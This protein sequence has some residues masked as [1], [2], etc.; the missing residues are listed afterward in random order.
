[1][2]YIHA[3]KTYALIFALLFVHYLHDVYKIDALVQVILLSGMIFMS[4]WFGFF[5]DRI[6]SI[7]LVNNGL[8]Q[9][10][11]AL[12]ALFTFGFFSFFAGAGLAIAYK[13]YVTQG[14]IMAILI[15]LVPM[16]P[17]TFLHMMALLPVWWKDDRDDIITFFERIGLK[18]KLKSEL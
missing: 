6:D 9:W 3:I 12:T 13:F 1:M 11:Y 15:S 2:T 17:A 14:F 8:P 16:S 10:V 5:I 18:V 7:K 4:T